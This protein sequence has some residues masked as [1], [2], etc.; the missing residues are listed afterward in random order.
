MDGVID[1]FFAKLGFQ[2]DA[3]G[4][5]KFQAQT[6]SLRAS[7]LAVGALATVAAGALGAMVLKVAQGMDDVGDFADIVDMTA[8]EVAAL[9]K[10]ASMNDS[11][12]EAMKSSIQ[13]VANVTGQAA[14]G[15]GRGA[16]TFE[17]LG[18]E[19]K[20]ATGNVKGAYDMLGE[21]ADRMQGM[22]AGEKLA[23]AS[24]LGIDASLIPLLSKGSAAFRQL[25]EDAEAANPLT[26]E[27]YKQADTIVKLWNK[28]V[29]G[30]GIFTKVLAAKLFPIMERVLT[31]WND[32]FKA[33]KK[34]T[35]GLM[36]AGIDLFVASLVT[37][38]D[39]MGRIVEAVKG[40]FSWLTQFKIVTWAA[41]VAVAA[42]IA[43]QAGLFFTQMGK[44]IA[45]AA[46]AM[47]AF[48]AA[49][50]LPVIAIGLIVGAILLLIDEFTNFKEG[51]DSLLGDLVKEFP[52][53][54]G[55]INSISDGVSSVISWISNL[56]NQLQPE[57]LA[58][59][60]ALLDLFVALWPVIKF[61]LQA[62]GIAIMAVLPIMLWL[63]SGIVSAITWAIETVI[64][65][66]T[67][68]VQAFT[69]A[70]NAVVSSVNF[71]GDAWTFF[72]GL[73]QTAAKSALDYVAG[74][75]DA[76]KAN[77]MAFIDGVTTAIGKVGELLGLSGKNISVETSVQGGNA[78]GDNSYG[79]S[80]IADAAVAQ[81]PAMTPLAKAVA[82][83]PAMSG[84]PVSNQAVNT[85]LTQG[86]VLGKA[87][88]NVNTANT[89]TSTDTTN[90][91]GT[92]INVTS[93]DP[94]KAGESVR[95]AFQNQIKRATRNG[96]S[97]KQ[98]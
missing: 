27:Q 84:A 49:G 17:M 55:V 65:I 2:V 25:K 98:L 39:W 47:L 96:Q 6:T 52:Q 91:T 72:T 58:L 28:A 63:A 21:I 60:N 50:A 32:L 80:P 34:A 94:A 59:G 74:L 40:V 64:S 13:G 85:P 75:F 18:F 10:V 90:I 5:D 82:Q 76:A 89:T 83:T 61:I 43:Y 92:V 54:L 42:L 66:V 11:S 51:N 8:R 22:S 53:L 12:F 48:S 4:L 69:G 68:L 79:A 45:G 3:Q 24:K 67:W 41:V 93:N 86:G 44:A 19:A 62:I 71:V 29:A 88:N 97:A 46:R 57:F 23:M 33:G 30:A 26:E 56:F 9:G 35:G 31:Y 78:M 20:D 38:W 16:K 77:V 15:I 37:L 81:T 70:V 36:S 95:E 73:L 87:A 14:L 7:I 1:S